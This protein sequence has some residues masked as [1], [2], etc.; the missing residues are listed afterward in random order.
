MI[1]TV[2][3]KLY[4]NTTQEDTLNRWLCSCC[5]VYNHCLNQRIK[6]YRR[7]N[8]SVGYNAQCVLLTGLRERIPAL[9]EVPAV[10]ARDAIRRVDRGFQAF[11][12]RCKAGD[13]PGFPRFRSHTRYN[14]LEYLA[15]GSY[16]RAGNLLHIPKLGLV[17]FRAGDQRIPGRQKLLRI[18]RRASGWFA[19]VL[20]DDSQPPP[21]NVPVQ[22]SVGIDVG[23][24]AFAT[25][26][27]G[28]KIENP[29]FFRKSERKL[30]RAQRQLSRCQ[31]GSRNRRKAVRH[32]AR[33]HERVA[34]QR[35]DFA[36]Q[37][38]R[39]LVNRFD[40]IG[41]EALNIKGLA[42]SRLAKSVHDAAWG[43]F[44][45]FVAYKADYAGK[46]AIP[47]NPSGTSQECP[48]CGAVARKSLSERT[49][50]CSCG[51]TIDRDEAAARVILARALRVVGASACGGNVLCVGDSTNVSRPRETGSPHE[52]TCS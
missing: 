16:P 41:F 39:R 49:H 21:P 50:A 10:F 28:E 51:L 30:K 8:E 14:S 42:G 35:K 13:K 24:V 7:R 9:A 19:Q 1:R 33:V 12:R 46:H 44:T 31:R 6:A 40:L 29:R 43:M 4:L 15:P 45:R 47:V 52:P 17:K 48:S 22:S 27:D 3:A 18:I 38:S 25:L 34:A 37:Q 36:H 26:S 11:F 20:V 5:W 2:E 32:V 23:L